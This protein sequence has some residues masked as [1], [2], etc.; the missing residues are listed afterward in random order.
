MRVKMINNIFQAH[1]VVMYQ[2]LLKGL[3]KSLVVGK[4][5]VYP[6]STDQLQEGTKKMLPQ[7]HLLIDKIILYNKHFKL[8][9]TTNILCF[10][11]FELIPWK[12]CNLQIQHLSPQITIMHITHIIFHFDESINHTIMLD[13]RLYLCYAV[14]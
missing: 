10:S 9:N 1:M 4:E 3:R 12:I 14:M 7:D 8:S 5:N 2:L 13:P 11:T 6:W